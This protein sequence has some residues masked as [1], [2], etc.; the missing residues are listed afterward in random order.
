[1]MKAAGKPVSPKYIA[2]ELGIK[3]DAVYLR[4]KRAVDSGVAR[5]VGRGE[6]E[7]C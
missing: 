3:V 2:G 7:A 5:K 1:M 4:L 6:Y